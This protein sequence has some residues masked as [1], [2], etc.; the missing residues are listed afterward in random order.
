MPV[1]IAVLM[2]LPLN[3]RSHP[4]ARRDLFAS[5]VD[6]NMIALRRDRAELYARAARR[7]QECVDDMAQLLRL[8]ARACLNRRQVA[9]E[10]LRRALEATARAAA[11]RHI[12]EDREHSLV[13]TERADNHIGS[14]IQ[15]LAIDAHLVQAITMHELYARDARFDHFSAKLARP[16]EQKAIEVRA[17]HSISRAPLLKLSAVRSVSRQQKVL[18]HPMQAIA[19][20]LTL[21]Q[22]AGQMYVQ[23]TSEHLFDRRRKHPHTLVGMNIKILA[24]KDQHAQTQA[25][26][27]SL[28]QQLD[29]ARRPPRP[30]TDNDDRRAIL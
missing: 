29:R 27:I 7:Q 2:P 3:G 25:A 18:A 16:I 13:Q 4:V 24:L 22:I 1:L 30:A 9:L 20:D 15:R 14:L 5:D 10:P 23:L 11:P 8:K 6:Q 12:L 21:D 19:E 17:L 28:L 26:R